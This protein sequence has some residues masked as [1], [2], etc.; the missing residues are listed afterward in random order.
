[1]NTQIAQSFAH[2]V[3]SKNGNFVSLAQSQFLLSKCTDNVFVSSGSTFGNTYQ[4]WYICD[5]LGVKEVQKVTDSKGTELIWERIV[6]GKTSI[7]DQK[8]KKR[9]TRQIKLLEKGI[10]NRQTAMDKGE[11]PD[12]ELFKTAM[13]RDIELVNSYKFALQSLK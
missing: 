7:Q 11:Y 10:A 12:V 8:E 5:E 4:I 9:I 2:L 6:D 1:M 3:K 13:T